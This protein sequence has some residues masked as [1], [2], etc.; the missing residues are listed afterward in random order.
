MK[1]YKENKSSLSKFLESRQV[2]VPNKLKGAKSTYHYKHRHVIELERIARTAYDST[3]WEELA[4]LEA[5]GCVMSCGIVCNFECV[6]HE[7]YRRYKKLVEDDRDNNNLG[8]WR[9]LFRS[10]N[11]TPGNYFVAGIGYKSKEHF[12]ATRTELGRALL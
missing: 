10:L 12:L 3:D 1:P 5:A 11:S 2:P 6:P 7:V 8:A 4:R 9:G